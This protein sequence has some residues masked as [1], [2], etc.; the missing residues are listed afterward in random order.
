MLF[1]SLYTL[2]LYMGK[3]E[4]YDIVVDIDELSNLLV[5]MSELSDLGLCSELVNMFVD[6]VIVKV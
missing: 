1:R 3:P 4:D 2:S 5:F 6:N